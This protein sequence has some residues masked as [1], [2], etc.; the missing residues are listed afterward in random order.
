MQDKPLLSISIMVSNRIDTIRKCMESIKPLLTGF[1]CELIALDT[2]G[3]AT[4]GSIDVVREYT[5]K[6]YR[7][8]WCKDFAKAR[9]FG[10]EK[11]SGEWFMFMDDDEWFEDVS[12]IVEFFTSG[13]YKKYQT[14]SYKIHTYTN[15]EG[16]FGVASLFRMVKRTEK[17]RFVGRVHEYLT[18]LMEPVKEFSAYIHHY[19]YVFDTEE[20]RQAHSERN[21]S[22]LEPDFKENPWDMHVRVQLLQEYIFMEELKDKARKLCEDTLKADKKYYKTNEFQWTLL[23]YVKMANKENDYETVVERAEMIRK[24]YPLSALADLAISTVEM[25]SRCKLEHFEKGFAIFEHAMNRRQYLMDN[26]DVKQRLMVLDFDTF[27]E[28]SIYCELLKCGIRC[29]YNLGKYEQ[30]KELSKERFAHK[31]IP[32]LTV[33]LLVSNRKDT[34]RKC[35]DS[36]KPLL[37][38]VPSELIVVDTVGEENSDGS[39]AIAR[40]Y[41]NHVVPYV[42][43]DDFAA[44]RNAGLQAAKGEWFLYLDD[45]E[46]F[47]NVE[48]IIEFFAGGEYFE[49]NSA[50]YIARNYKDKAGTAYSD[51]VVG[52]MVH[53][54]KNTEFIGC[55]NEIFNNLYVPHKEFSSYVHHYGFAYETPEEKTEKMRYTNDLLVKD[56][57]KYPEN[58]RNRAQLAAVLSV[59]NPKEAVDL[60]TS[61]LDI[62]RDKKENVQYQWQAVVLFGVLENLQLKEVA[63]KEYDFLKKEGLLWPVTEKVVCY[64][65]TRILILQGCYAKAYSYAKKFFILA[66]EVAETETVKEFDKYQDGSCEEEMLPLAAFCAWQAKAYSDAWLY[67]ECLPWETMGTSVEDTMWKVFALAEDHVDEAALLRIIK[68]IMSKNSLK[69]ILGKMMQG[70]SKVK[71]RINTTLA[72]QRNQGTNQEIAKQEE[73]DSSKIILSIGILVSNR[74]KTIRRC[75]DSIRPLL[76]EL[77][78]ELI[79][80]DTVGEATDGSVAVAKEYTDKVYH[81]EWCKDFAD[82]RNTCLK[83]AEGEWFLF[84]DDDEWFDSVEELIKFFKTNNYKNYG[85]GTFLIRNYNSAGRYITTVATRMINRKADTC[86]IGKIHETF[87]EVCPP[88]KQFENFLHHEGYMFTCDE[89]KKEHQVRNMEILKQEITDNGI[90]PRI[91]AQIVQELLS[92]KETAGE[93]YKKCM[94]F[95]PLLKEQGWETDSCTQ[96]MMVASIRYFHMLKDYNNLKL[97]IKKVKGDYYL[98]ELAELAVYGVTVHAAVEAQDFSALP[99]LAENYLVQ[100][101]WL[102]EHLEEKQTQSQLDLP[103]YLEEEYYVQVIQA[104]AKASNALGLYERAYKFWQN[105]PWEEEELEKSEYGDAYRETLQ[106]LSVKKNNDAVKKEKELEKEILVSISLLVSNRKDTIRKSMESIKPLLEAVSSELIAVDTVGA[107]HSDGSLD[108]VKEYTNHIVHF[109]WCHDFAAARNAGLKEARGKWYLTLDDDEWFEDIAPIIDFFKTGDYKNY[110]RAWYYVRNYHNFAGTEW[111]DTLADRMCVITEETRYEGRVHESLL[112]YPEKIM[113]FMCYVH[114]YG[115]VY[116]NAEEAQKHSERNCSLLELEVKDRPSDARMVAQLVQEYAAIGRLE[117]GI[118]LCEKWLDMYPEQRL[119]PFAQATAVM[120]LRMCMATGDSE[121][122]AKVLS[123]LE[124]EFSLKEVPSLACHVEGISIELAR[125]NYIEVLRRA[126]EF[127]SLRELIRS[128]G[129]EFAIQQVFDFKKYMEEEEQNSVIEHGLQAIILSGQMEMASAFLDKI[130]WLDKNVRPFGFMTQLVELYGRYGIEKLFFPYANQIISN[131]AMKKPF[132]VAVENM[133]RNYPEREVAVSNWLNG[134]FGLGRKKQLSP[135]MIQL[136]EALK[137]NVQVLLNEG[138]VEEA[139]SLLTEL[140]KII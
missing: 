14:A 51:N 18:P 73:K 57:E 96:W 83:Y 40:E 65:L 119:H 34:I 10:L 28:D 88:G 126:K 133:V 71:E 55:V 81:Y 135:E 130:N 15:R 19:G 99:D 29:C 43:N 91:C 82:A 45:D 3:E 12:E 53:R 52:R 125:G 17:T 134:D 47:E 2:M 50:T 5:D 85:F 48:E 61:T 25:H 122:A 89:E 139:K 39:L 63:E 115:Y 106:A 124:K 109:P 84:I 67:Y 75:L 66:D 33:S 117:E 44:A 20:D 100:W 104:G 24:K 76:S 8:E 136:V 132:M 128:K 80:L 131:E 23:A 92:R 30:A 116:K 94:E 49:Y 129:A 68:R 118:E 4:D 16:A 111:I 120:W 6:I 140:K 13:E 42:W 26:P 87:N 9:N 98:T 105:I 21:I 137:A 54:A 102:A 36:V 64:R 93:G 77:P 46:W 70:N 56:L 31:E 37:D 101:K 74:I 138:K 22:L 103:K 79:V 35:L 78:A 1:P 107:E 86:F 90:S 110:D 38:A 108:I 60:C 127:F 72:A 41:T 123:K 32:V 113:Q 112:P 114:H 7:F 121:R 69:L 58:L 27:L 97:Q 95:L 62:C 11:C 59:Q